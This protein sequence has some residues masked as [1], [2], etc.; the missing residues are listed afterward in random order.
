VT[1]LLEHLLATPLWAVLVVVFALPALESSAFLGFV[2]PGETA[3]LLGGVVAS[4]GRAPVAAVLAAGIVGAILG[5]AV[6]Y[7]VGRRWGRRVLDSTLG[8]FVNARHF[9]RAEHA[10]A[11]RGGW[12]VF[13]GRFTVALRVMIPGLSGM[14]GMPFKRFAVAN[15]SGA[16]AWGGLMVAAGY[17]AGHSWQS[18]AHYVS[19]AGGF[20]T[21]G[22]VLLLLARHALRRPARPRLLHRRGNCA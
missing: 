4:Q 18:V 8:R 12:A 1:G 14:A 5:D 10:L 13:L 6:G 17:L 15:V 3:L 7:Q 11:R 2:F 21:V 9:D 19:W 20:V 22:V 16:V